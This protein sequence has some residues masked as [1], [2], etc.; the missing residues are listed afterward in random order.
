MNSDLWLE[1]LV[2]TDEVLNVLDSHL[3]ELLGIAKETGVERVGDCEWDF[4]DPGASFNTLISRPDYS[5][6]VFRTHAHVVQSQWGSQRAVPG[7][8]R[9]RIPITSFDRPVHLQKGEKRPAESVS[10]IRELV[11]LC[12]LGLLKGQRDILSTYRVRTEDCS[13]AGRMATGYNRPDGVRVFLT[14]WEDASSAPDLGM[15]FTSSLTRVL[16]QQ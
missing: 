5:T 2:V 16:P 1:N 11:I 15:A 8:K 7:M 14:V 6:A 9:V 4:F 10:T 13:R 12:Y 3:D